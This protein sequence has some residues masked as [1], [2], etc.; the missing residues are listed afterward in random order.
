MLIHRQ[1]E[2]NV[3]SNEDSKDNE[4]EEPYSGKQSNPVFR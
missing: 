1:A 3:N 4:I 2:S